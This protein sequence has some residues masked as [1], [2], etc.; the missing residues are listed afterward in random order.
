MSDRDAPLLMKDLAET[1]NDTDTFANQQADCVAMLSRTLR[2]ACC[3]LCCAWVV[4][5]IFFTS[6]QMFGWLSASEAGLVWK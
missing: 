1:G 2:S 4:F 3:T 6:G 5:L